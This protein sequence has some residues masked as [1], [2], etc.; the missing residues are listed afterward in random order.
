MSESERKMKPL[1]PP[2]LDIMKEAV[3]V[4]DNIQAAMSGDYLV[5]VIDTTRDVPPEPGKKMRVTANSH[6]F[7]DF[8]GHLRGN[9]FVGRR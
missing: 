3:S 1:H 2:L 6:G 4:G 9:V 5:L 8:P 7:T